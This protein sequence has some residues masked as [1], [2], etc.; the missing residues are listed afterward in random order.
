MR[1]S[2]LRDGCDGLVAVFEVIVVTVGEVLII[3]K[4][5]FSFD[6]LQF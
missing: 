5:F 2:C 1:E 4:F 3:S 6:S